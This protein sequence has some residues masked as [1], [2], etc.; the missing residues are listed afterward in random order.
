M[1][2]RFSK[3]LLWWTPEKREFHELVNRDQKK[4]EHRRFEGNDN[5]QNRW[6]I[7]RWPIYSWGKDTFYKG[8]IFWTSQIMTGSSKK[9]LNSTWFHSHKVNSQHIELR[10]KEK[11]LRDHRTDPPKGIEV[12]NENQNCDQLVRTIYISGHH[13]NTT[14]GDLES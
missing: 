12:W 6:E 10:L 11:Y 9:T 7:E 14:T 5:E 1:S 2:H 8:K 4:R 13:L 3:I